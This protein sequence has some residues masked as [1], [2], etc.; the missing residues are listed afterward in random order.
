ML[1]RGTAANVG[2]SPMVDHPAGSPRNFY[3]QPKHWNEP[4]RR[5]ADG[6][7]SDYHLLVLCDCK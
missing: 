7:S 2:C 4:S 6:I 5:D 1:L 3:Q